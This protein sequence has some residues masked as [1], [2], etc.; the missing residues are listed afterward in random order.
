MSKILTPFERNL[1]EKMDDFEM[2]YE[3]RSWFFLQR[4]MSSVN[5]GHYPW[6]VAL[7]AT[8]L[9]T[10]GG[11]VTIYR[12]RHVPSTALSASIDGRFEKTM[13]IT[14]RKD[15]LLNSNSDAIVNQIQYESIAGTQTNK[16]TSASNGPGANASNNNSLNQ[17]AVNPNHEFNSSAEAA[18]IAN[19]E[20]Q[21]QL[22]DN[23]SAKKTTP[24]PE[25]VI[26]F[27]A[28]VRSACVGEEVEFRVTQGP[29]SNDGYLWDFGD[30]HFDKDK[31]TPKHKFMKAGT[32]DVALSVTNSK[33]QITT[34]VSNDLITI[35][36][37]PDAEFNWE[38]VNTDPTQPTIKVVDNS[39]NAAVYGWNLANG[40]TST[41]K[42]PIFK[43]NPSGKQTIALHVINENGCTDVILKQVSVNTDFK[44]DVQQVFKSGSEVF[45]P[46]GLKDSKVK[47]E[48]TI[49]DING[50]QVFQT[51]SRIKGWDGKLPNGTYAA[52]GE[53]YHWKVIIENDL[54]KEQKYF[55]GTLNVSP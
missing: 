10:A 43:L 42:N 19:E 45:M 13:N 23:V 26:S 1:K 34:V 48:M 33:G 40:V 17:S 49:F 35:L 18:L 54:S 47:F 53:S 24:R 44:L 11:A 14:G 36:D 55:N 29:D 37:S 38:F 21:T 46:K 25:D 8:I 7:A 39:E 27:D 15:A 5:A 12:H 32:Y 30:N 2:P 51:T 3:Q 4:Q 50:N 52:A 31:R 28:P 22:Q 20:N 6:I 16:P 9:V 41:E